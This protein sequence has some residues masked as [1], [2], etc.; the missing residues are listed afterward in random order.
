MKRQYPSKVKDKIY[1]PDRSRR[2]VRF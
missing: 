2:P 1:K